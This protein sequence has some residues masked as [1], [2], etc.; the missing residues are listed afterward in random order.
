MNTLLFDGLLEIEEI[1]D[2]ETLTSNQ[3][4]WSQLDQEMQ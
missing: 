3:A 4:D 2:F 1:R